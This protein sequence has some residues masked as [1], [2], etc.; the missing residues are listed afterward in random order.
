MFRQLIE[1][2]RFETVSKEKQVRGL[3]KKTGL[4]PWTGIGGGVS[5]HSGSRTSGDK[6]LDRTIRNSYSDATAAAAKDPRRSYD[7]RPGRSALRKL[8]SSAKKHGSDSSSQ[9][10]KTLRKRERKAKMNR[11]KPMPLPEADNSAYLAR[12]AAKAFR[13]RRKSRGFAEASGKEKRRRQRL[14]GNSPK[15]RHPKVPKHRDDPMSF[16]P[17][18]GRMVKSFGKKANAKHPDDEKLTKA[19][20]AADLKS[21]RSR[22][23][24]PGGRKVEGRD[25]AH[26]ARKD[27]IM[28]KAQDRR[29]VKAGKPT[30]GD[31][32][33][34][35]KAKS[36]AK[37][38]AF[39]ARRAENR[40]MSR[41]ASRKRRKQ[42]PCGE[43]FVHGI[44]FC[45]TCGPA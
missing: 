1:E 11:G 12:K 9:N 8:R 41:A 32:A 3:S 43:K 33:K 27:E 44:R 29:N 35:A 30:S 13:A 20:F 22:P 16:Y 7:T 34:A 24:L 28:R 15:D 5:G 2:L 40:K 42:C 38:Q 14:G 17:Q 37:A 19:D 45:S 39:K 21:F 18:K 26:Q 10:P 6:D 23:K 36:D 4:I 31:V 25:D